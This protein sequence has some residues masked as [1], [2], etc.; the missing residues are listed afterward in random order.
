[1]RL[2][3]HEAPPRDREPR[4]HLLEPLHPARRQFRHPE[5]TQ[6]RAEKGV[7][8]IGPDVARLDVADAARAVLAAEEP[9]G[10]RLP[11]A[12]LP[13]HDENA[14]RPR[15]LHDAQE[16]APELDD[17]AEVVED[18]LLAAL[19]GEL[20]H[21]G[22]DRAVLRQLVLDAVALEVAVRDVPEALL[23]PEVG[24][25]PHELRPAHAVRLAPSRDLRSRLNEFLFDLVVHVVSFVLLS[26]ACC[27]RSMRI[28]AKYAAK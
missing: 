12:A 28:A 6:D 20:R 3:D 2:V 4:L 26:Y 8:R 25:V 5:R 17:G 19:V 27:Y 18:L 23:A 21:R 13:L 15:R 22:V 9:D 16:R 1:M 11:D 7:G 14:V 10:G 24:E